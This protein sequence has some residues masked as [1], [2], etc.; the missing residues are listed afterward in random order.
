MAL[1]SRQHSAVDE[2]R[3]R[4]CRLR[5]QRDGHP[6]SIS[7]DHCNAGWRG[8]GTT[9][10]HRNGH[11]QRVCS[12]SRRRGSGYCGL[13]RRLHRFAT[14][15][16]VRFHRCEWK[17]HRSGNRDWC[18]A[19]SGQRGR[20]RNAHGSLRCGAASNRHR[21]AR[22]HIP[23]PAL[24]SGSYLVQ[25]LVSTSAITK[26][27]SIVGIINAAIWGDSP[28]SGPVS[29]YIWKNPNDGG[30]GTSRTTGTAQATSSNNSL[31]FD[32]TPEDGTVP[33][34]WSTLNSSGATIGSVPLFS[35]ALESDGYQ[36]FNAC[37]TGSLWVPQGGTYSIQIQNKDQIMFGMGGGATSTGGQVYGSCWGRRSPLSMDFRC[38]SS[39]R[40]TE[41]GAPS[42]TRSA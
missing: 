3:R 42:R 16:R 21:L 17:H 28:H 10:G 40:R 29:V 30:T 9:H 33:V 8:D 39:R 4:Q 11:G 24:I 22:R 2:H 1:T 31:I 20:K 15:R 6:A 13:S 37:I 5:L 12:C 18:S 23:R 38:S 19:C 32:S 34:Q 35:P 27:S 26:V 25:A 41:K 36:D 14:H 7:R